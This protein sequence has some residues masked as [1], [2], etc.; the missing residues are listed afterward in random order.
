MTS[1]IAGNLGFIKIS[2]QYN[3]GTEYINPLNIASIH[4][5]RFGATEIYTNS[6]GNVTR[7]NIHTGT[8]APEEIIQAAQE[9]LQTGKTINL[10]V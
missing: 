1:P 6:G 5:D 4:R 7:Y 2:N 10:T 3:G 8:V 9:A